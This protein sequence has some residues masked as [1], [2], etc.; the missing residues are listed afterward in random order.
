[1]IGE[2]IL[3]EIRNRDIIGYLE[4]YLSNDSLFISDKRCIRFSAEQRASFC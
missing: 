1:M 2:E 4:S 3:V